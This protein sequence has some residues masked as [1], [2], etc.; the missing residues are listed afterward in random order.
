MLITG[1][2]ANPL[3]ACSPSLLMPFT[4]LL[5]ILP[6]FLFLPADLGRLLRHVPHWHGSQPPVSQ[7]GGGRH[8]ADNRV[9]AVGDSCYR[10]RWVNT[11]CMR[12][13]SLVLWL[14]SCSRPLWWA[15]LWWTHRA[16]AAIALGW[17]FR[18]VQ[19]SSWR[20]HEGH[21][22]SGR[23]ED[24]ASLAAGAAAQTIGQRQWGSPLGPTEW[25]TAAIV[26]GTAA[27]A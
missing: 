21:W 13:P 19:V 5:T 6:R 1:M 11:A 17:C 26:P 3:S 8:W 7:P 25:A 9:D 24:K 15:H 20:L 4:H 12:H 18:D 27:S 2:A 14:L 22:L 16:A 23:W 10:A